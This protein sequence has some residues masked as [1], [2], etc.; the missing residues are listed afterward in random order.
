MKVVLPMGAWYTVRIITINRTVALWSLKQRNGFL[1]MPHQAPNTVNRTVLR[2]KTNRELRTR[3]YLTYS[4]VKKLIA[5]ARKNRYGHRDA[6]M[7]L[8]AFR[9]GLRASELCQLRWDQY[10]LKRGTLHVNRIKN[11]IE[12]V[13]PVG[14]EE[15]RALR[16]LQREEVENRYVFVSERGAPLTHEGLLKMI[17]RA[18]VAA[19][20]PFGVHPHMLRHAC[21]Y[22]LA[23]DGHDTRAIQL[24]MGHKN[25]QNTVGYT[26][27]TASR[28]NSFWSD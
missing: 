24:Y 16:K 10:D 8:V 7:I 3:E 27:L 12:S 9:H 5:V 4:E 26:Q 25:I 14:G 28:F 11:G 2:R 19:K 13:H 17:K 6:T 23:N 15:L 18:G 21:G 1:T 22:K 20:L